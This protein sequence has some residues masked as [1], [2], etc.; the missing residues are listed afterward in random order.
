M[1]KIITIAPEMRGAARIIKKAADKGII[2]SMGHSDATYSET[3]SGFHA[4]ARGITHIFNAMRPFHHREPGI[5]G[6][7]LLNSEIYIEVIAD[8]YHLHPS[9]IELIFKTKEPS[10]IIIVSD[11]IKESKT[12]KHVQ[13]D[14]P[15]VAGLF[16]VDRSISNREGMLIGGSMAVMEAASRLIEMGLDKN[17]ILQCIT[18]NAR[19]YLKNGRR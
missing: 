19:R 14:S 11:S 9:A 15:E 3:E 4:G 12:P 7:G 18:E 17:M 5:I 16:G 8:P 6:F 2:P 13:R 10:R 1:I